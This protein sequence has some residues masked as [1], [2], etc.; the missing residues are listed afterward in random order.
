MASRVNYANLACVKA[1]IKHGVI[2][3]PGPK[4]GQSVLH[5]VAARGSR[6]VC[7]HGEH[8]ISN[9]WDVQASDE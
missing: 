9:G 1:A 8:L 3:S 2:R 7:G 4:H 5:L 6:E